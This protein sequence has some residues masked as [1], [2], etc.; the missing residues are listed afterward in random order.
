MTTLPSSKH[1]YSRF[2]S[3]SETES[4]SLLPNRTGQPKTKS[5][6][7]PRNLSSKKSK[8]KGT[9]KSKNIQMTPLIPSQ[10][11]EEN[12]SDAMNPYGS[13][14]TIAYQN[15]N[16]VNTNNNNNNPPANL[17]PTVVVTPAAKSSP[18]IPVTQDDFK[19]PWEQLPWTS[20]M[21]FPKAAPGAYS[22]KKKFKQIDPHRPQEKLRLMD[23]W[24][25]RYIKV[26]SVV[27]IG[28][29]PGTHYEAM[30]NLLPAEVHFVDPSPLNFQFGSRKRWRY[31][32]NIATVDFNALE[33]PWALISDVRSTT[34]SNHEVC[35]LNDNLLVMKLVQTLKPNYYSLKFRLPKFKPSKK[36]P[37]R[38]Y[39]FPHGTVYF[40]PYAKKKNTEFR[41][42]GTQHSKT[43]SFDYLT[44]CTWTNAIFHL[45]N[46][47]NYSSLLAK[48]ISPLYVP[49]TNPQPPIQSTIVPPN[50][51]GPIMPVPSAPP[52]PNPALP[53]PSAPPGPP[54]AGPP[55]PI[56]AP[57]PN[58][59]PIIALDA[60]TPHFAELARYALSNGYLLLPSNAIKPHPSLRA[61]RTIGER[62][63]LCKT[64]HTNCVIDIGGG[65]RAHRFT[66]ADVF[67]L[68]PLLTLQDIHKYN[69]AHPIPKSCTHTAEEI[70]SGRCT[71]PMQHFNGAPFTLAMVHSGY[72]FQPKPI[73]ELL[74]HTGTD[75]YSMIHPLLTQSGDYLGEATWTTDQ[76]GIITFDAKQ[77]FKYHHPRIDWLTQS[78]AAAVEIGGHTVVLTWL[79]LSSTSIAG[80]ELQ[81]VYHFKLHP[82]PSD[83]LRSLVS[84]SSS[85]TPDVLDEEL[86]L[87]AATLDY[88]TEI[89]PRFWD[90]KCRHSAVSIR[91][92]EPL[93]SF[94]ELELDNFRQMFAVATS[95]VAQPYY[96]V[97]DHHR[98]LEDDFNGD[99][100]I[101]IIQSGGKYALIRR[102]DIQSP[103]YKPFVS[104]FDNQGIH[105]S[106]ID[107]FMQ[108]FAA[109][110][111]PLK[112][113]RVHLIRMMTSE[114]SN[115]LR[116]ASWFNRYISAPHTIQLLID[117]HESTPPN[118]E[119]LMHL[120]RIW[121]IYQTSAHWL[122]IMFFLLSASLILTHYL[123][124]AARLVNMLTALYCSFMAVYLLRTPLKLSVI[125]HDLREGWNT[126]CLLSLSLIVLLVYF[127]ILTPLIF[128]LLWSISLIVIS[129][130]TWKYK[131]P[132]WW[133]AAYLPV[134]LLFI[135]INHVVHGMHNDLHQIKPRRLLTIDNRESFHVF[136]EPAVILILFII[137]LFYKRT[138]KHCRADTH[139]IHGISILFEPVPTK[140]LRDNVK[141]M[142]VDIRGMEVHKPRE[143][144]QVIPMA[145]DYSAKFIENGILNT[146]AAL[147][148]RTGRLVSEVDPRMMD[149]FDHFVDNVIIKHNLFPSAL[150]EV[151]EKEWLATGKLRWPP[152]KLKRFVEASMLNHDELRVINMHLTRNAFTKLDITLKPLSKTSRVVMG[153][154]DRP[155]ARCALS[156]HLLKKV[157]SDGFSHQLG[158]KFAEP[159]TVQ[160]WSSCGLNRA[161][162]GRRFEQ[163]LSSLPMKSPRIGGSDFQSF[164]GSIQPR[165]ILAASRV[166][167]H[168]MANYP[169]CASTISSWLTI[170]SEGWA[171]KVR[172]YKTGSSFE[173]R[174]MGCVCTGDQ[175]TYALN[176]LLNY[177]LH[178]FSLWES[179]TQSIEQFLFLINNEVQLMLSGDDTIMRAESSVFEWWKPDIL[180][181]LGVKL[182]FEYFDDVPSSQYNQARFFHVKYEDIGQI[183]P[184]MKLG[185]IL[186]KTALT[187]RKNENKLYY[188]GLATSKLRAII[189][190]TGYYKP[191][192][193]FYI[194]CYEF[195]AELHDERKFS[196]RPEFY[197][198][199]PPD[200]LQP[201][202]QT[203]DDICA[204]YGISIAQLRSFGDYLDSLT[205]FPIRY[206]DHFVIRA[207]IAA[208]LPVNTEEEI[209]LIRD[210]NE[211]HYDHLDPKPLTDY[212]LKLEKDTVE[213]KIHVGG[214][215]DN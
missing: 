56:A 44:V 111:A 161:Q 66:D 192:Q 26:K 36:Y 196:Y 1:N 35:V 42:F 14:N 112:H 116:D 21:P 134:L 171:A 138:I 106:T 15:G 90:H 51:S 172:C 136:F 129:V 52:V 77:Q 156:A 79:L 73:A 155:Q 101:S 98:Y 59:L 60:Y 206:L 17:P 78:N 24:F 31:H 49:N 197:L 70:I 151:T 121:K 3:D 213:V 173:A 37:K 107:R 74:L 48:A 177:L 64:I 84:S 69:P 108:R 71:C 93:P 126:L 187:Y 198:P 162:L 149:R 176:C 164:D 109:S 61:L 58:N 200:S 188:H 115:P 76:N 68:K 97:M 182:E 140:T 175:Y 166:A 215:R 46:R 123:P 127:K 195:Y 75:L 33:K 153:A 99:M 199:T 128:Y 143:I 9:T 209:L 145:A 8:K 81:R 214:S 157:W 154:G 40:Q 186:T 190:E 45:R 10:Q 137:T 88:E 28:A 179:R 130:M 178:M 2:N 29:S 163:M 119:Y 67:S 174:F 180:S 63:M 41:L 39:L 150:A 18:F 62:I 142:K 12:K 23:T 72:Y 22:T 148:S 181:G 34:N 55:N 114:F 203:N 82:N 160:I 85:L 5:K 144:I 152:S 207:F 20:N 184:C 194:R 210:S 11:G 96:I 110:E 80:Q 65:P 168:S 132:L 131:T 6:W 118:N 159:S 158:G 50:P 53:I 92:Q 54:P 19:S 204:A 47:F 89:L 13:I 43:I 202:N 103:D 125:M 211:N 147:S 185:K 133:S 191:L 32:K 124:H 183:Y 102:T 212:L 95:R 170:M 94:P 117:Y 83:Y 167:A 38:S 189:Q 57:L 146:A 91:L 25:L 105:K 165:V 27:I 4:L 201:S 16:T 193:N 141:F 139:W 87:L 120:H 7:K 135:F 30:A 205:Q 104:D 113:A 86:A 122:Y 100:N 208:D 169:Q